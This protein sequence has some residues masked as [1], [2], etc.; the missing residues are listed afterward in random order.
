MRTTTPK[1]RSGDVKPFF[2]RNLPDRIKQM[3]AGEIVFSLDGPAPTKVAI[4]QRIAELP[5]FEAQIAREYLTRYLTAI[6]C[7]TAP[8]AFMYPWGKA[9]YQENWIFALIFGLVVILTSMTCRPAA[10]ASFEYRDVLCALRAESDRLTAIRTRD[11]VQLL[12]ACRA[13]AKGAAYRQMV[14]AQKREFVMAE[15]ALIS[16]EADGND[17][18]AALKELYAPITLEK[19]V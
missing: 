10:H 9:I 14:V 18:R 19:E 5:G 7:L 12:A 11:I 17:V 3:Q 1:R 13:S 16:H 8:V 2:T 6:V 4:D 15:F